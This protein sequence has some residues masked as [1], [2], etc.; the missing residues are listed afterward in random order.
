MFDPDYKN[1]H[2]SESFIDTLNEISSAHDIPLSEE[3]TEKA[4]QLK[5]T[6]LEETYIGS[7]SDDIIKAYREITPK[8]YHYNQIL[9][10]KFER[11]VYK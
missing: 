5:E 7:H 3:H 8:K 11:E 9:F 1:L 4:Q 10:K 6:F 2:V